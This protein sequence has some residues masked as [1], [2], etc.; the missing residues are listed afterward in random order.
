MREIT[1]TEKID[2][3]RLDSIWYGGQMVN[4][5]GDGYEADIYAIGDIRAWIKNEYYCDKNNGGMFKEYL[6]DN[7]I[8]NDTELQQAIDNGEIE[9][10][11]NNWFE[12]FVQTDDGDEFS[13]VVDLEPNDDFA[14]LDDWVKEE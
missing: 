6:E 3:D 5:K 11:N 2:N 4:I 12:V 8:T 7:G 13:E 14:W 9:F 10:E 1:W